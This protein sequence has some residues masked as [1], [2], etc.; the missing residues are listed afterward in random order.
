MKGNKKIKTEKYNTI[1]AHIGRMSFAT[2]SYGKVPTSVLTK[3]TGH[4]SE[5]QLLTYIN[6]DAVIQYENLHD[7]LGEIFKL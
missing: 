5:R 1:N 7:K 2:N 4:K 3:I 6:K